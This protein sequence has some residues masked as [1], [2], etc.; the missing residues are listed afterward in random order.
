[1]AK[2]IIRIL[3]ILG[4]IYL[5]LLI[6]EADPSF[7]CAENQK[8]FTWNRDQYWAV[9]ETGFRDAR[10][11]G[12]DNLSYRISARFDTL[13]GH[14]IRLES[15]SVPPHDPLFDR[16]ESNLFELGVLLAACP[17][18]LRKYIPAFGR[19]RT[20]LKEQSA[21][22]DINTRPARDCIYR[23]LYGGR[24]AIE[25]IILQAPEASIEETIRGSDE[26]SSTPS[27]TILGVKIHSGDILVS[28]GGAPTSA[29][30]ARGN[31]YPGNFS[32]AAL[33]HVDRP[34]GKISIIEAHIER[35]VAIADIDD[36]F[37]DTKLRVMILRLRS[38][39]PAMR[40]DPI[41]PHRA[42]GYALQRALD[43]HIPYDFEMDAEESSKMFCSEVVLDAYRHEG[44]RLWQG[45]STISQAGIRSWLAA[46][47]VKNFTTQE[48]SD[49]E[50]DPQLRV[51]AE[52]RDYK[53]LRD[54]R[55]DNAVVDIMLEGAENGDPLE[56]EWYMLP[57][58]R[59]LKAY[60]MVL[61]L[62]GGVG[63]IPE[64]MNAT[65]ALRNDRFSQKHRAIKE[66][67]IPLVERFI[68][69][70]EYPP[71]YWKL[72][73]LARQASAGIIENDRTPP[74]E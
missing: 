55:L 43:E 64:G 57:P 41:L 56:Y 51:V 38:D 22:W 1:M 36:Y 9:L 17:D 48:P 18:S 68:E 73:S 35:G 33:V 58:A 45:L 53:T 21:R 37:R 6:P 34:D 15:D 12:C 2:H 54:D 63:P 32:H 69:E 28:R 60:S 14:I 19:L 71:P 26:A 20:R 29:L 39:L 61:N 4:A 42:A 24:T 31:D 59:I 13:A 5:L 25:E 46:F 65:A 11:A 3:I 27:A 10:S 67:L 7:T 70:N 52:W 62:F 49:L 44:V 40:A 23:L 30:I 8:S 74:V 66:N 16:I 72:I 50:Y 47:G